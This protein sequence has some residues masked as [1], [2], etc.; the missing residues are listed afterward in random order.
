MVARPVMFQPGGEA[1]ERANAPIESVAFSNDGERFIAGS[2]DG[3]A[4]IWDVKSGRLLLTIPYGA[5]YVHAV[6]FSPD[7]KYV[8]LGGNDKNGQ[9]QIFNAQNGAP[10]RN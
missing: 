4:R 10:V 8:A 7:D 2:W 6:A 1:T 3:Q 5:L 9:W